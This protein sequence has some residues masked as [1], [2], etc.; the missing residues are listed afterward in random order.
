ME[1]QEKE[2]NETKYLGKLINPFV[3]N[4]PVLYLLKTSEN[5]G[6]EKG[7]IANKYQ[8]IC[9]VCQLTFAYLKSLNHSSKKNIL[10]VTNSIV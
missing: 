10:Q 9:E 1:L 8:T 4:V 6:V 3:P 7:C 5:L 2:D